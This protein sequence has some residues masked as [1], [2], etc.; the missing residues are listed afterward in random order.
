MAP[1]INIP[2]VTR[3]LLIVLLAQSVLSAA[4]R[5]R[6]WSEKSEIVIP[7]LTLIPSLSL[8]YPWTLVTSTLVETNVFTFTIAGL[9]LFHGGR[10]LERAWSSSDLI[11]FVA[12]VSL[13][14]NV[15]TFCVMLFFYALTRNERWTSVLLLVL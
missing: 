10:Y 8:I 4:I 11:K 5:Y 6:E 14:A 9:T 13:A 12:L 1:R 7:Y 2:P 15:L 3:A